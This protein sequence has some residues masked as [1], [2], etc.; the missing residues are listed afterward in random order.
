MQIDKLARRLDARFN[1][2]RRADSQH[3]SSYRALIEIVTNGVQGLGISVAC[4]ISVACLGVI[5]YLLEASITVWEVIAFFILL[6]VGLGGF[7]V[8]DLFL[9]YYRFFQRETF[10]AARWATRDDM[11]EHDLLQPKTNES[12]GTRDGLWFLLWKIFRRKKHGEPEPETVSL[13]G[14]D[15]F[16]DFSMKLVMFALHV[17]VLGPQGSGKTASFIM[18]VV[19]VWAKWGACMVLDPKREIF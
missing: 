6:V 17:I 13:G 7:E 4:I 16:Y 19:R 2:P 10:G 12:F 18:K 8:W 5:G 9:P 11:R 3:H 1:L 14:F 15:F